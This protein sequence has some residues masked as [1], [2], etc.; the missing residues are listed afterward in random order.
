MLRGVLA[1]GKAGRL[2]EARKAWE[3]GGTKG[4]TGVLVYSLSETVSSAALALCPSN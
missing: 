2:P 4:D 3:P 1:K